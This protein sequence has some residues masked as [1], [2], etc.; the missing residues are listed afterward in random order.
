MIK[1]PAAWLDGEKKL[2]T[3]IEYLKGKD[4]NRIL[5]V[6]PQP[7]WQPRINDKNLLF[8][9][10]AKGW[11]GGIKSFHLDLDGVFWTL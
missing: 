3:E 10:F 6:C 8:P 7:N 11:V 9:P 4:N 5:K 2:R 1:G